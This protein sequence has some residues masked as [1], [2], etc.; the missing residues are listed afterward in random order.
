MFIL[1]ISLNLAGA[2]NHSLEMY[3]AFV[4]LG[5]SCDL[6]IGVSHAAIGG[7]TSQIFMFCS[8]CWE[9]WQVKDHIEG[10]LISKVEEPDTYLKNSFISPRVMLAPVLS[11]VSKSQLHQSFGE[12]NQWHP[13]SSFR[14]SSNLLVMCFW[15][16]LLL[17]VAAF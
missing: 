12:C 5:P 14:L 17:W 15:L 4:H 11:Y 10:A 3:L 13:V 7:F 6:G 9:S 16:F 1:E 8:T 2:V